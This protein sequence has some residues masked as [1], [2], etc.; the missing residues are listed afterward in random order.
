MELT[1]RPAEPEDMDLLYRWANDPVTRRNGFHT[2]Q[3]PYE[4]HRAW[5]VNVM[6]DASTLIYICLEGHKPVGQI[7]LRIEAGEALISYSVDP[8]NRG[9]GVGTRLLGLAEE[10]L[11]GKYPKVRLLVGEVKYD[12]T[13]SLRAFEKNGYNRED[14]ERCVVCRKEI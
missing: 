1:L 7:R 2:E 8:E 12:N 4:E 3:I 11:K 13:A 6:R 14:K 5:F 9:R 10:R